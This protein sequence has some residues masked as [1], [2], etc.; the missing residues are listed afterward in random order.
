VTLNGHLT[1]DLELL[2]TEG[3]CANNNKN[4]MV[5]YMNNNKSKYG[6]PSKNES[7]KRNNAI[8]LSCT[9]Q[10]LSTIQKRAET[11][12]YKQISRYLHDVIFNS[13]NNVEMKTTQ[14]P[15][16]NLEVVGLLN[17]ASNNLNQLA[18]VFNAHKEI[19][20]THWET[21]GKYLQSTQFLCGATILCSQ[22]RAEEAANLIAKMGKNNLKRENLE[23]AFNGPTTL[24]IEHAYKIQEFITYVEA[25]LS[26]PEGLNQAELIVYNLEYLQ[27]IMGAT[28][29]FLI[30]DKVKGKEKLES[31]LDWEAENGNP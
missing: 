14:V 22:G 18:R 29:E 2:K 13:F 4:N 28:C 20:V 12:G 17:R 6:R 3:F 24:N 23:I 15:D 11:A 30:G 9:N 16:I 27:K 19:A 5:K 10:E 7:E 1:V 8:K 21:V 26:E 25:L 31:F